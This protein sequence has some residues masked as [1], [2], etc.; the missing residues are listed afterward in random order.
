MVV[1]DGQNKIGILVNEVLGKDEFVIKSLGE[2][3]RGIKAISGEPY[4]ET[5]GSPL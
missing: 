4:S 2:S 1:E 5:E 3:F